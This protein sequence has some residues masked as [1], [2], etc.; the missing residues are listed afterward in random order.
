MEPASRLRSGSAALGP[1]D[2]RARS[3]D[4]GCLTDGAYRRAMGACR[5]MCRG[6]GARPAS[7][8][9][10]PLPVRRRRPRATAARSA[11]WFRYPPCP[12]R[13]DSRGDYADRHGLARRWQLSRGPDL[14]Q[15]R[16]R[17]PANPTPG[18]SVRYGAIVPWPL[19]ALNPGDRAEATVAVT[20][21]GDSG[22][23]WVSAVTSVDITNVALTVP[24]PSVFYLSDDPEYVNST[25]LLFRGTVATGD[26]A[27]IYYYHADVGLPHDLDVVLTAR[28]R[29][30]SILCSRLRVRISTSMSVGHTVSPKLAALST[31]ARGRHCRPRARRAVCLTSRSDAAGR[32]GR[33]FD[34][35]RGSPRR[36]GE[37]LGRLVVGGRAGPTTTWMARGSRST[38]TTVTAPSTST[39]S[40]I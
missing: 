21:A 39:A 25:G 15:P 28:R 17:D 18:A 38:A 8:V 20:I 9:P 13:R 40:A 3:A 26:A 24:L 30:A 22:S 2:T 27:R 23:A 31:A 37:R 10:T 36:T 19:P 6:S 14:P 4:G 16:S 34:R 32:T 11:P 12:G 5:G 33:R 1:V 29:R 35:P 7:P